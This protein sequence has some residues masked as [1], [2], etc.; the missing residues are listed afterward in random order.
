MLLLRTLLKP[1]C[2]P[3]SLLEKEGKAAFSSKVAL[4]NA[5]NNSKNHMKILSKHPSPPFFK[6]GCPQDGVVK[7]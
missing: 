4:Q 5:L 1:P 2:R 6:E 3:T 7:E